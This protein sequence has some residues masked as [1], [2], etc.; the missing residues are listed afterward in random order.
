VSS[1]DGACNAVLVTAT[2]VRTSQ[3][4]FPRSSVNTEPRG[5]EPARA[6]LVHVRLTASLDQPGEET[7]RVIEEKGVPRPARRSSPRPR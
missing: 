7:S 4:D 1:Q 2:G 6:L 3:N 5:G